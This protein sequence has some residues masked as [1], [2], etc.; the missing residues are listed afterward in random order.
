MKNKENQQL[1]FKE[2]PKLPPSAAR[3]LLKGS[4]IENKESFIE[5]LKRLFKNKCFLLLFNA[6][7]LNVGVYNATATLLNQ[8]YVLH[9]PV[10][11]HI[12][13]LHHNKI[14]IKKQLK[15][16]F[17]FV[18]HYQNEKKYKKLKCI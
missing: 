15:F 3:A 9:F 6:H 1:V 10:C 4:R 11:M 2:E 5:P 13:I 14:K 17:I 12:R 8:L 7:G 16:L 18:A